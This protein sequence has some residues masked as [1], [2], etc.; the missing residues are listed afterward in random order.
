MVIGQEDLVLWKFLY[1]TRLYSS[2]DFHFQ[3]RVQTFESLQNDK[4]LSDK[5][6]IWY[7][8]ASSSYLNVFKISASSEKRKLDFFKIKSKNGISYKN[9]H[10]TKSS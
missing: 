7:A 4:F 10:K 3:P 8:Y 5:A 6:K 1:E 2:A 9:L